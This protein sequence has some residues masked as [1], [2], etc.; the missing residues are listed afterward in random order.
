MT[1]AHNTVETSS[2]FLGCLAM[3][4]DGARCQQRKAIGDLWDLVREEIIEINGEIVALL[5]LTK[6]SSGI[7][8]K[9][10]HS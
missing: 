6:R 9:Q 3:Q 8:K 4:D 7:N 10:A 2:E 1:S 5:Y